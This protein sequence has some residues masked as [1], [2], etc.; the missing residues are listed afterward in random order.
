MTRTLALV[1]AWALL[2]SAAPPGVDDALILGESLPARLSE[3]RFFVNGRPNARVMP[4]RLN[5]P[6]FSD[7]AEKARYLYVPRGK[8]A[9]YTAAGQLDFPVGTALIKSFGYPGADAGPIETRVLLKRAAGWVALPYVWT[10]ADAELK[11]GGKRLPVAFTDP[12]GTPRAISYAVPNTNQCKE[13]HQKAGAL[14]P[15]GPT[16]ANLNDGRQLAALV[17]AGLLDRAPA[18]APRLP[19]WDDPGAPLEAR[20][21]AY[22]DVNC[23]HCHARD[24]IASNSGLYLAFDE[25]DPVARG[26]LKRPVAAG[27]GSGGLDFAIVPGAPE[28]SIL[29]HR[30][31]T[32]E[33]G[34]AMPE[35]GRTL[36]HEEGVAL[37][38]DYIKAMPAG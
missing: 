31:A 24:G 13:C 5:T 36:V 28:R 22:L 20:A 3:F 27:R 9:R 16:A 8:S 1:L 29:L 34:V 33:P 37:I 25:R 14:V 4:Y 35:L 2:A 23:G 7:H 11:R 30:M 32:T 38:R 26:R 6:L 12:G 15:I 10:G 21:E 18:D 17:V 19:R